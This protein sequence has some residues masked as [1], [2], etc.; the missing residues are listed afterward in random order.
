MVFSSSSKNANEVHKSRL[1]TSK[2]AIKSSVWGN[3]TRH[4]DINFRPQK[5]HTSSMRCP[6]VRRKIVIVS[7]LNLNSWLNVLFQRS[8]VPIYSCILSVCYAPVLTYKIWTLMI[9]S[10]I[11]I[12]L[13]W[14]WNDLRV[15][16]V[17]RVPLQ[18]ATI[19]QM[20]KLQ[21]WLLKSYY[22]SC[23]L[24]A[25]Y[26]EQK[27]SRTLQTAKENTEHTKYFTNL[28]LTI[29]LNFKMSIYS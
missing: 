6:A 25:V 29:T 19:P 11:N 4:L 15:T 22:H 10:K 24:L 23:T 12:M 20:Y 8:I 26:K 28:I 5:G 2:G 13:N 18:Y 1:V 7:L 27:R 3:G 14:E 17:I 21:H 16:F 9:T